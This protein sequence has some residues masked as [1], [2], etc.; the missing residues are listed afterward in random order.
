MAPA[1][2]GNLDDIS[3]YYSHKPEFVQEY[4]WGNIGIPNVMNS[5]TVPAR[6]RYESNFIFAGACGNLDFYLANENLND[7]ELLIYPNPSYGELVIEVPLSCLNEK[8]YIRTVTGQ[9]IEERELSN[10]KNTFDFTSLQSGIYFI[11]IKN[12]SYKVIL[13]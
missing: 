13:R 7:H 8:V 1:G 12:N 9:I 11:V 5:A 4:Q 3:Y 2:T 6:D 10:I